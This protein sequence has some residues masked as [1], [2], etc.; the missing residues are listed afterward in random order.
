MANI[1]LHQIQLEKQNRL[2]L[3]ITHQEIVCN[4]IT[5]IIGPNGAGKTMLLKVIAGLIQ[6]PELQFS[7]DIKNICMVLSHTPLLKMRVWDHFLMLK[8]IQPDLA[9]EKLH[10]VLKDFLLDHLMYNPATKI[11]TGERQRLAIARAYL[12]GAELLIL[13]EPTASLDPQ[14]TQLIESKIKELAQQGIKFLIASH[15]FAQVKRICDEVVFINDGAIIESGPTAEL[16]SRPQQDQT[17]AFI[18]FYQ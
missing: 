1:A 8:D 7:L 11:S 9:E 5:G 10:Q 13:D 16:F 14:S 3:N 12:M 4:S 18:R 17:A 15:D 2:I 6:N